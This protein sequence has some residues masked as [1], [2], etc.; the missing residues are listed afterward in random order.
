LQELITPFGRSGDV[1]LFEIR[2]A[3]EVIVGAIRHQNKID[4]H[5]PCGR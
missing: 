4:Y 1:V 3:H 2:D 5:S